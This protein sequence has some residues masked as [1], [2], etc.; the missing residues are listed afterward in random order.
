VKDRPVAQLSSFANSCLDRQGF[1]DL[2]QDAKARLN[3]AL[4]FTPALCFSVAAV[5][6]ALRSPVILGLVAASA[7]GAALG[8]THPFDILYNRAVRPLVGGPA[9]PPNPAPRRFA[10][11][12]ATTARG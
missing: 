2:D 8:I 4:R 7:F 6:V 3:L 9:L 11:V 1:V 5:G 12:L 10:F